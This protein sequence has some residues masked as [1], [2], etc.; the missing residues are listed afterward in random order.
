ME[1]F[2]CTHGRGLSDFVLNEFKKLNKADQKCELGD[3]VEGK[4]AFKTNVSL[5]QLIELKTV[6]RLF[7]RVFFFKFD[8]K[9]NEFE[10]NE[11]FVE[12]F[13]EKNFSLDIDSIVFNEILNNLGFNSNCKNED[14]SA[15][16]KI[17]TAL[18]YRVNFKTTGKWKLIYKIDATRLK[19]VQLIT[20]KIQSLSPYFEVDL[21]EPLLEF[22]FHLSET[23]LACG[24]NVS[25]HSLSARNFLK[26]V[27]L[28]STICS[29]MI[30]LANLHDNNNPYCMVLDPFC[31]K[32]TILAEFFASK[33]KTETN[34]FYLG[35]D[36]DP[37]QLESSEENINYKKVNSF[38]NMVL[39]NIHS[40]SIFPY[41]DSMFDLIISDLPFGLKHHRNNMKTSTINECELFYEKVLLE[42]GRLLVKEKAVAILLINAKETE[43]FERVVDNDILLKICQK[44]LVSLGE[45]NACIFK[46]INK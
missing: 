23:C 5:N 18:K 22:A 29:S 27:G 43:L 1:G 24:L 11:S 39:A 33:D 12:N 45:T 35:S 8:N 7:W 21:R 40:K 36:C 6:E 20:N 3:F 10:S 46:L 31:G 14:M 16:K 2:F 32:S 42:F 9:P 13:I 17:C 30:Q 41:R 44:N 34:I 28:R 19:I 37:S 26:N 38:Y 4:I 15:K 25:K